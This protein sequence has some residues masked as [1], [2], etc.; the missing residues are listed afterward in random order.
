[1]FRSWTLVL[2][3]KTETEKQLSLLLES[4]VIVGKRSLRL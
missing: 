2:V 1:M 3:K 4:I